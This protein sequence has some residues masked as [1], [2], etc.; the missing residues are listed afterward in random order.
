MTGV[1][2]IIDFAWKSAFGGQWQCFCKEDLET[3]TRLRQSWCSVNARSIQG[4]FLFH[5]FLFVTQQGEGHSCHLKPPKLDC[6]LGT[7]QY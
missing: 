6:H 5:R 2:I 1:R 7:F 3:E 4:A